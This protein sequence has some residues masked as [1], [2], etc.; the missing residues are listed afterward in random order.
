MILNHCESFHHALTSSTFEERVP[1]TPPYFHNSSLYIPICPWVLETP[2]DS[3][4]Y[5][6]CVPEAICL[7]KP[8]P[9][10]WKS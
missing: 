1:P 3:P 9:Q 6:A 4:E 5:E 7:W 8:L 10:L 2:R